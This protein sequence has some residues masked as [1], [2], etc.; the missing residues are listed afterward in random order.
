[1]E[2]FT[3]MLNFNAEGISQADEMRSEVYDL[4]MDA[5]SEHNGALQWGNVVM[6][7]GSRIADKDIGE[8]QR[9]AD[10]YDDFM[11]AGFN[12]SPLPE[13]FPTLD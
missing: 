7:R 1:M 4:F 5:L 2:N 3:I 10:E 9:L 8:S 13:N 11:G 12:D 6:V